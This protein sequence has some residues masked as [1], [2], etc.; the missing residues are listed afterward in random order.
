MNKNKN[1]KIKYCKS[2]KYR[3]FGTTDILFLGQKFG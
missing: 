2:G 1:K 3:G